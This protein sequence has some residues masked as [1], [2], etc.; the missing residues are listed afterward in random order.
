MWDVIPTRAR[1][2]WIVRASRLSKES[3][4]IRGYDAHKCVKGRK[5]HLLVDTLGL[6]IACYVTP[7][8]LSDPQ[9]AR[10]LLAGRKYFVPRLEKIWA[11]A[12]YRGKDLAEWGQQQGGWKLEIVERESGSHLASASNHAAGSLN[13]V[14]LG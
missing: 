11:D 4:G 13:A 14:S 8:D 3:A 12:A 7:A 10:R 6:P 9:G 1:P 2:L 5:R